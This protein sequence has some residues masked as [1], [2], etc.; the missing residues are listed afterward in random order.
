M[1]ELWRV[2]WRVGGEDNAG[3]FM[4]VTPFR[5]LRY[6]MTGNSFSKK[7]LDSDMASGATAP[8]RSLPRHLLVSVELKR[9]RPVRAVAVGF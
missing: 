2:R 5:V 6:A 4:S 7:A 1:G 3:T 9:A 8:L